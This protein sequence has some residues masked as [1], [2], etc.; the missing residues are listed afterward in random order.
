MR[1]DL[2]QARDPYARMGAG[3][4]HASQLL[5]T[6]TRK[7]TRDLAAWLISSPSVARSVPARDALLDRLVLLMTDPHPDESLRDSARR[8]FPFFREEFVEGRI[9]PRTKWRQLERWSRHWPAPVRRHARHLGVG[10]GKL[11][12]WNKIERFFTSS[13][14]RAIPVRGYV[15][16]PLYSHMIAHGLAPVCT[17]WVLR[18]RRGPYYLLPTDTFHDLGHGLGLAMADYRELLVTFARA[19]LETGRYLVSGEL[20]HSYGRLFEHAWARN[21]DGS[22]EPIGAGPLAFE[23]NVV[24]AGRL[25]SIVREKDAH[26]KH[27]HRPFASRAEWRRETR[28]FIAKLRARRR[29]RDDA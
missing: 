16:A 21:A 26:L 28:Q 3:T 25:E 17:Q 23:T 20:D 9:S 19:S 15:G 6:L 10:S 11:P 27:G 8:P 2:T 1:L 22:V 5:V 24:R 12:D 14:F 7:T 4:V 29:R 18:Y 13:G